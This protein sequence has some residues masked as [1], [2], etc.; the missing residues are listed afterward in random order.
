VY[1]STSLLDRYSHLSP[2][3]PTKK[4]FQLAAMA[5]LHLCLKLSGTPLPLPEMV[6]LSRGFFTPALV[7]EMEKDVLLHTGWLTHPPTP[8]DFVELLAALL[9]AS[10][11][12]AADRATFLTELS[13]LHPR[14]L[15]CRPSTLAAAALRLP[16]H[17]EERE[18][19]GAAL[20]AAGFDGGGLGEVEGMLEGIAPRDDVSHDG[21]KE[22]V[23]RDV[24]SPTGV[25]DFGHGGGEG[26][27]EDE[28]EDAD[29]DEESSSTSSSA[30]GSSA[31]G[32]VRVGSASGAATCLG[33]LRI[34]PGAP[35]EATANPAWDNDRSAKRAKNFF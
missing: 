27:A 4:S 33:S 29:E 5:C 16:L 11:R 31:E 14:F 12:A 23:V 24:E 1:A 13:L 21:R 8:A 10:S 30:S 3:P 18:A 25:A 28:M 26:E 20:G 15:P 32:W 19:F 2:S 17:G 35:A 34:A 7:A 22:E 6:A 9:P